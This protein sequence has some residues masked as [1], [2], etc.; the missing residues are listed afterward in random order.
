MCRGVSV[1][2]KGGS[3]VCL[4]SI[5]G[6]QGPWLLLKSF[7]FSFKGWGATEAGGWFD[8]NRFLESCRVSSSQRGLE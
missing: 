7:G 4:G 8:P 3:I 5:P 2:G 1:E 6:F